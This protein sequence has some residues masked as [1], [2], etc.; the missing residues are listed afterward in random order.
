MTS[1]TRYKW[2]MLQVAADQEM[3]QWPYQPLAEGWMWHQGN[4]QRST[5]LILYSSKTYTGHYILITNLMH[6]LLFIH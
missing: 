5:Y 2:M 6:W 4:S 1:T 3:D